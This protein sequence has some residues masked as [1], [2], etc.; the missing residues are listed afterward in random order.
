MMKDIFEMTP[1]E[2]EDALRD[3]NL[4]AYLASE[5][6]MV[7]IDEDTVDEDGLHLIHIWGTDPDS[8]RH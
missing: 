4:L 2:L 8:T 6:I 3:P 1:K 5:G 7:H